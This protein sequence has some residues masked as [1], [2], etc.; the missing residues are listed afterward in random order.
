[1]GSLPPHAVCICV[2]IDLSVY[3]HLHLHA[4]MKTGDRTSSAV[5]LFFTQHYYIT[6]FLQENNLN[7]KTTFQYMNIS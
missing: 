3:I 4:H 7:K 5:Q 2:C 1:M 6:N